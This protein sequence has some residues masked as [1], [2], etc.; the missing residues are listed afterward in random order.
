MHLFPPFLSLLYFRHRRSSAVQLP[1]RLCLPRTLQELH[2]TWG[3][4]CEMVAMSYSDLY[5]G[6]SFVVRGGLIIRL[7]FEDFFCQLQLAFLYDQL[8]HLRSDCP[9]RS[10]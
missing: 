1:L 5:A 4:W 3:R 2:G 7:E 10:L 8:N 9:Y 6:L